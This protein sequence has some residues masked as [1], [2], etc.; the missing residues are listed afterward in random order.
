MTTPA[1]A[2][3]SAQDRRALLILARRTLVEY[4]EDGTTPPAPT[5][6]TALLEPRATFVTLRNRKTGELRGCRGETRARRPLAESVRLMTIA[7]AVDDPRFPAVEA[8]EAP[9]LHIEINV[10]TPLA[11]IRAEDVEVGRHGLM[12]TRGA[13]GGLLLPEVAADQ[14]W[15]RETYLRMVCRKAGLPED[16]WRDPSATLSGFESEAW[17]EDPA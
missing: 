11:P 4:L 14:G 7:A 17:G 12:I 16:A 8:A 10:L 3:L 9:A 1:T 15:D 2:Q 6:G 13:Y 5:G